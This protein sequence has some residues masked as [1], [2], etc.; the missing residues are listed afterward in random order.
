MTSQIERAFGRMV[1]PCINELQTRSEMLRDIT[2]GFAFLTSFGAIVSSVGVD[3]TPCE[4]VDFQSSTNR[5][6]FDETVYTI[7]KSSRT[8]HRTLDLGVTERPIFI[9]KRKAL[10]A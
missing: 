3:G 4:A 2:G 5:L 7:R 1:M 8:E 10:P 6:Y 9:K